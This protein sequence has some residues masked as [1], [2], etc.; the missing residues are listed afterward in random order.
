VEDFRQIAVNVRR[1]YRIGYVPKTS[2]DG[3]YHRVKVTVHAPGFKQLNVRVRDG[4]TAGESD[5]AQ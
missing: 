5:D 1:G 4:Y 3:S 2:N